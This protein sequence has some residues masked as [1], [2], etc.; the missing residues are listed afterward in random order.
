MKYEKTKQDKS[1]EQYDLNND[2]ALLFLKHQ[3]NQQFTPGDILVRMYKHGD[4]W[5]IETASTTTDVHKKYLYAFEN[6]LNVGY[7]KQ[8]K[9]NGQL[10]ETSTCMTQFDFN[11]SK[12][13]LDPEYADHILLSADEE[14]KPLSSFKE[15][16]KF[17]DRAV[18]K[19]KDIIVPK[20]RTTLLAWINALVVG[21]VFH[22]GFYIPDMVAQKY[23]VLEITEVKVS[24]LDSYTANRL[25]MND[26]FFKGDMIR[27]F[28]LEVL[29]HRWQD[30]GHITTLNTEDILR[31]SVTSKEPFPL[32]EAQ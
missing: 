14:F 23:R 9:T 1:R 24:S 12:F 32:A 3:E 7:V 6:E 15:K 17:R 16:K 11:N 31:H 30:I 20:D 5:K 21:D 13:V 28:K 2:P 26:G 27:R 8:F 29:K 22:Y 10:S 19:N 4:T 18:A 25:I